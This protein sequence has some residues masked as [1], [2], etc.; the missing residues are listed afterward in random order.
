M[1][2]DGK[3][4]KQSENKKALTLVSEEPETYYSV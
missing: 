1:A 3:D 2:T 4:T